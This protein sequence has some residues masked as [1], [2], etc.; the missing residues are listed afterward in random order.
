MM[1]FLLLACNG[2]TNKPTESTPKTDD[3]TQESTPITG[4][5]FCAVQSIFAAKC[6]SCHSPSGNNQGG[7]DLET[8]PQ[9]ALVN[10]ASSMYTG[11]TLVIPGNADASFLYKKVTGQQGSSGGVMPPAGAL[12]S[13]NADI[14]RTWI[15]DG[16]TTEC[17]NPDTN[18]PPEKYHPEGWA[19][20]TNHGMA[21][22]LSEDTCISCHAN[23]LT[24]GSTGVSCDTCHE[25]NWRTDC[26]F[27]HG[28]QDNQTGAPPLDIRNGNTNVMTAAHTAHVE[29]TLHAPFDCVQCH[30]KPT[31][32]LSQNHLFIADTTP[33]VSEVVFSQGLS[34]AAVWNGSGCSNLYCHGNGQGN[35]GTIQVGDTVS[36]G[37][38]HAVSATGEDSWNRMGGEHHKHLEKGFACVNCHGNTVNDSEQLTDVS[39]HVNGEVDLSLV[40]G[41]TLNGDRS[42]SGTCHGKTHQSEQW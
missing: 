34:P 21:A 26:T 14:I 19:D 41:M 20:P 31:D 10:I 23:D 9:T 33:A 12:D 8:N 36:C 3:S 5:G 2:A 16:A 32:V 6:N 27:C 24:G 4:D 37:D 22:K 17:A 39:Y 25:A 40:S 11:E 1:L 13:T 7:L 30:T 29:G 18:T 42:C 35:N 28:G 38:C 15:A